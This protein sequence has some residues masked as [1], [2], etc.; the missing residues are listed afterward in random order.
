M[1][2]KVLAALDPVESDNDVFHKALAIAHIQSDTSSDTQLKLLSV[3]T[4]EIDS[5]FIVPEYSMVGQSYGVNN[6]N[7]FEES[8]KEYQTNNMAMLRRLSEQ[9]TEKGIHTGFEQ[10]VGSPGHAI[11][12]LAKTWKADLI[13]VGSHQRKGLSEMILGSVSNYVLHH[14]PCSVLVVHQSTSL[15]NP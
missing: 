8:Y 12:E 7:L 5:A 14:A 1:F 13:V 10:V 9:S 6:W 2:N 11:C 4:A 3:L 15:S